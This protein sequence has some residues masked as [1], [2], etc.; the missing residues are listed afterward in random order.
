MAAS[1][2]GAAD[3]NAVPVDSYSP[4]SEEVSTL[5]IP[6]DSGVWGGGESLSGHLNI[7]KV[8]YSLS[9]TFTKRQRH[10]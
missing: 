8:L 1:V 10:S 4:E 6:K 3:S 9:E 7:T 5:I 2:S